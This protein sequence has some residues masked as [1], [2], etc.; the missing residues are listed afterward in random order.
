[1]T[2]LEN[3]LTYLGQESGK[4][5]QIAGGVCVWVQGPAA[6][7]SRKLHC[8]IAEAPALA[9]GQ[10]AILDIFVNYHTGASRERIKIT[11][12]G[13]HCSEPLAHL[14]LIRSVCGP[15]WIGLEVAGTYE[16]FKSGNRNRGWCVKGCS[17]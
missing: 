3:A 2:V 16:L 12:C 9:S 10:A 5:R 6:R 7:H 13:S 4:P 1:M 15:G 11:S 8:D 17:G 14:A